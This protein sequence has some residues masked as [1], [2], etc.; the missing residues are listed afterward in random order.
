MTHKLLNT[1]SIFS[2]FGRTPTIEALIKELRIMEKNLVDSY[3]QLATDFHNLEAVHAELRSNLDSVVD[4][5]EN[6]KEQV[7]AQRADSG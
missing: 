5:L 4:D 6:L 1:E 2:R 3:N 7:N